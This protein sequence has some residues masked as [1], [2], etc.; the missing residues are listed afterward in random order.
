[1][2]GRPTL[3]AL[4]LAQRGE[5]D[6][7]GCMVNGDSPG[8]RCSQCGE[9]H[10]SNELLRELKERESKRT[11][12]SNWREDDARKKQLKKQ[13][14]EILKSRLREPRKP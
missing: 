10:G 6:L 7:G 14:Q 12:I 2:Y 3:E 5:I 9:R 11:P 8:W 4:E 1:V 13:R